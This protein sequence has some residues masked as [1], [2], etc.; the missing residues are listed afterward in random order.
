M[1]P[2]LSRGDEL[3]R[4][5]LVIG[6]LFVAGQSETKLASELTHDDVIKWKHFPRNWPFVRGI[7]RSRWIPHTKTQRPVTRSFYVFFDLRL[8]KRLSKK[9]RGWWLETLSCSLWRQGNDEF[10]HGS[11][12]V[13]QVFNVPWRQLKRQD[14]S[15]AVCVGATVLIPC[16]KKKVETTAL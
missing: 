10:Q 2:T 8:N 15:H 12:L 4:L 5:Y 14:S 9:P 1:T 7:H 3:I 6:Y 16:N 11:F 13:I